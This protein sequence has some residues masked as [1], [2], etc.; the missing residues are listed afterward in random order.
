MA[1]NFKVMNRWFTSVPSGTI[2][3]KMFF[4]VSTSMSLETNCENKW[5]CD[6]GY[7]LKTK[8]IYESL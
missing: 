3:N 6:D 2:P 7:P 1:K 5:Y 8:S 4:H